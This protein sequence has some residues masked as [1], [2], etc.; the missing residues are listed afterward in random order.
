MNE[1]TILDET[2]RIRREISAEFDD[3]VHAFFEHL[4]RREAEHPDR[5]VVLAPVVPEATTVKD[6]HR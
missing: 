6:G 1:E 3:D 4:R 2:H 5:V